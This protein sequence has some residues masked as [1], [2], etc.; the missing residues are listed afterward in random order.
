MARHNDINRGKR[1]ILLDLRS[2]EGRDVFWKLLEDADVV[3]QNY[4]AGSLERLGLGY[5]EVRKRKPD[6]IYASLNA[7]GHIGPWA[8]RPGHEGF[9]QATAGMTHRF[10]GDGVPE[11]QPNP[12][13][14]YGTGFMGALR[15]RAGPA[16]PA[17][18][19]RGPAY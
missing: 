4:R 7:Y 10:G 3:A 15:G 19:W 2:D 6:I 17:A 11:S 16:A 12:V 5:E 9:A 8:E 1:S 18:H 13:N 14:D